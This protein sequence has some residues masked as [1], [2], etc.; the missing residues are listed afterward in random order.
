MATSPRKPK[1]SKAADKRHLHVKISGD[2]YRRLRRRA[3]DEDT[4]VTEV[5][6]KALER[7]LAS[8]RG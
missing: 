4:T 6:L 1:P 8:R 3:L 7:Y 5:T 2:L